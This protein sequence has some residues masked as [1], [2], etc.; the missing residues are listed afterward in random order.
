MAQCDTQFKL[1]KEPR[2]LV[3]LTLMQLCRLNAPAAEAPAT[4]EKKSPDVSNQPTPAA[5]PA[6]ASVVAE[7]QPA[8]PQALQAPRRRLAGDHVS[9]KP[10]MVAAA[11]P[12][13][14]TAT[15]D[16]DEGPALDLATKAVNP[17]LLT[18]VWS[19]YAAAR[20]AEGKNSLHATLS[21]HEPVVLGPS[22]VSFSIVNDVQENY[23]REE[24]PTLLSHLRRELADPALQLEVKKEAVVARPRYTK[25]DKFTLMAEK[26]P[27]L[28]KLREE[29]DLDLG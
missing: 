22:L 10:V 13:T 17:A 23:M 4:A 6:S 15:I 9:I 18:R 16:T 14:G 19:A 26:N 21:A 12:T 28:Q 29:L 1:S 3:E 5:V 20:K 2:M 25:L 27:A 11:A 7:P 24:K 8:A